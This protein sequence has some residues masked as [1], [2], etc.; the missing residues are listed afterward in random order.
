MFRAIEFSPEVEALVRF[1]EETP[2]SEI[3]EQALSKLRGGVTSKDLITA[4]A[5]AVVRSTE[6]PASHHGGPVHPIAGLRGCYHTA[7]R[8]QGELGFLPIIQHVT[9]SNHHV[10]SP[11][12]GPYI[13]PALAPMDGSVDAPYETFHDVES[14]DTLRLEHPV[15][16]L[17]E[18]A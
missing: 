4:S 3:V 2:P 6:L 14:S 1:V 17:E 12:M 8:L 13:M 16:D 5:L 9:L 10:H 7:E 15:G 18:R 11:H